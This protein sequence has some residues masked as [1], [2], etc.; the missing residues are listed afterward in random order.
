MKQNIIMMLVLSPMILSAGNFYSTSFSGT[1]NPISE[2]SMWTN[3][4][5]TGLDWN[6]V[7]KTPGLAFGTQA[8]PGTP[9]DDSIAVLTGSWGA[10]QTAQGTLKRVNT[11]S[12]GFEEMELL[13]RFKISAHSARGYECYVS[14]N[15]QYM[16]VTRWNGSIGDWTDL[17]NLSPPVAIADGDVIKA[18]ISGNTI[19]MYQNGSS[20]GTKT[21]STF[22]DGNPGIGLYLGN[23]TSG[24]NANF[25]WSQYSAGDGDPVITT[26]PTGQTVNAGGSAVFTVTAGGFTALSYQWKFNGSN[27]GSNSA[28]YTRSNCQTSDSGGV[29]TVVV[30]D[31]AGNVTSDNATLTVNASN[32]VP[33]FLNLYRQVGP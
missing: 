4:L 23:G 17:G 28:T 6:N 18:T 13:L 31:T 14:I 5:T 9:Y 15:G 32:S 24:N 16:K 8:G 1:E 22:S 11:D 33:Q 26:Q 30:T 27:V 19:T 2:S 20:C 29:V 21:D 10:T 3:G 12:A 25:G 7:R